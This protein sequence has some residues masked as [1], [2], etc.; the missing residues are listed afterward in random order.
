M[1]SSMKPTLEE[2]M[3]STE[4][5]DMIARESL[6]WHYKHILEE[7][8]MF[9]YNDKGHPDDFQNNMRLKNHLEEVLKYYG[10]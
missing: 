7:I 4:I 8:D 1:V 9:V 6:K 2:L 10:N 5:G 3:R